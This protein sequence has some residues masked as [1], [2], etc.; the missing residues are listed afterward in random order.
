M[1][2]L[3][4]RA[5]FQA[6]MAAGV[7][8]RTAHFALHRLVLEQPASG[9]ST[10]AVD[11]S[12]TCGGLT[13]GTGQAL[14]T[15]SVPAMSR[16]GSSCGTTSFPEPAALSV[17]QVQQALFVVA[18]GRG[19]EQAVWLG[20]L[21]PK[22]W[23]RRSVTRH[24]IRRQIYAVGTEFVSQLLAMPPAAYVVR[25]RGEFSRREFVSAVSE[26]LKRAVRAE[27]VQL[28]S[29]AVRGCG[30]PVVPATAPPAPKPVPACSRSTVR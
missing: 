1:Q 19:G 11:T 5:Q 8:S 4:S 6:V 25:L 26:P 28:F 15:T 7:C 20:P 24:A 2:R 12:L 16:S 21:V 27:L 29:Y 9:D 14:M 23:A 22:R 17:G 30:M 13:L 10:G 18:G 3:R